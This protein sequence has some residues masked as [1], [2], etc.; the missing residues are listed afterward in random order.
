M[1]RSLLVALLAPV[2]LAGSANAAVDMFLK[3]DGVKGESKDEKHKDEIDIESFSW[4][5]ENQTSTLPTSGGG[6]GAGKVS[7]QDFHFVAK[8]SM[9][10]P[11]IM[12]A[13]AAG[14]HIR[15]ATLTCRK[16]GSD[17][18]YY[19]LIL[20]N[21]LVRSQQNSG[22]TGSAATADDMPTEE[23]AFYFES[24]TLRYVAEDG[25]ITEGST[26]SPNPQ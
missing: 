14:K 25:T 15:E 8:M 12:T 23:V 2:L 9:A 16:A 24:M 5:F 22:R 3:L 1:K 19:I 4:K 11:Q 6:G 7:M 10:T 17:R 20:Q 13:C 18:E 26:V 21:V